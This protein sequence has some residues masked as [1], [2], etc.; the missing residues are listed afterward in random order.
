ML[1]EV[2]Y[3]IYLLISIIITVWVGRSLS[4]KGEAFLAEGIGNNTSLA[5]S[6][7]QLHVVGFYLV[8]LGFISIVLRYGQKPVDVQTAMEFLSTK[9][10]LV[11]L[12]VGLIHLY[13]IRSINYY[14]RR[15]K[16][17]TEIQAALTEGRQAQS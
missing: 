2:T 12:M 8:N 3:L 14:R 13:N 17:D 5:R 11:L 9:V 15:F 7:N 6:I 1:V 16:Q 4:V 10:G